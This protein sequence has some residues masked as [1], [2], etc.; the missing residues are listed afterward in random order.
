LNGSPVIA[1]ALLCIVGIWFTTLLIHAFDI[2]SS[3]IHRDDKSTTY[4]HRLWRTGHPVRSAIHK[5]QIGGL[6]VGSVTTSEYLLLYVFVVLDLR[7]VPL[8]VVAFDFFYRQITKHSV[9]PRALPKRPISRP[10]IQSKYKEG[11]YLL[12]LQL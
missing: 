9:A 5:P 11:C 10:E 7:S 2:V 8:T 3:Y 12:C 4:G 1:L 6:V